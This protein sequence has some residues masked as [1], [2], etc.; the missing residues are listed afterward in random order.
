M[1]IGQLAIST[2]ILIGYLAILSL[3]LIK[4]FFRDKTERLL[5]IY[6]AISAV[7]N[8]PVALAWGLPEFA[9]VAALSDQIA[10]SGL[11]ILAVI[12]MN[13]THTFL[14]QTTRLAQAWWILS[15]FYVLV[16]VTFASGFIPLTLPYI[17]LG[18]QIVGSLTLIRVF[19]VLAWAGFTLST[20]IS[21]WRVYREVTSP[22]HRN[23]YRYWLVGLMLLVLGD[24]LFATIQPALR[25]LGICIRL[26]SALIFTITIIRYRLVD[27]KT[28][29]RNAFGYVTIAFLSI[30]LSLALVW[31]GQQ[32]AGPQQAMYGTLGGVGVTAL[33]LAFTSAPLRTAIQRFVDYRLFHIRVNYEALLRAYGEKVIETLRLEPLADLI[34]D[35]LVLATDIQRGALYLVRE[36][37]QEIG[38]LLLDPVRRIGDMP[39]GSFELHP[40]SPLAA[41]LNSSDEPLTQYDIDLRQEFARILPD[42]HEWLTAINIEMFLPIHTSARLVG[43]IVLGAKG[44]GEVYTPDEIDWLKALADQTAVALENARLFDQVETMSVNV[45]RLNADLERAYQKLQEVDKL[46]SAFIGIIT[47]ELRSPFVAAG[48]SVQLLHRYLERKMYT[49]L[50]MQIQQ[51]EKELSSGRKMIDSVISFSSLLS[52]QGQL[53]LE[54]TDLVALIQQTVEPLSKMAQ[55]RQISLTVQLSSRLPKI[56][57][58]SRQLTEAIYHMVH[59]AIKFNHENGWVRVICW[60]TETHVVFKVEDTGCGIPADKLPTLWDGF[61][62]AAD[63]L[64]RGVEGLGLGLA[65]IK[66][67]VQTHGGEVWVNSQVGQGSTFGFR[68]PINARPAAIEAA[69]AV[70]AAT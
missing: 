62:Q 60:P 41:R 10:L 52:K 7:W 16:S 39:E 17:A 31:G 50:Q 63:G 69:A 22:M 29:Y 8:V 25:L 15:I 34:M 9:T 58:D 56:Q 24:A 21:T 19:N 27:I 30:G 61:T 53:Q 42:E 70:P 65:L 4:R 40:D 38:G 48:F 44:S 37:K 26:S 5:V 64:K 20:I 13:L 33:I 3:L 23:R 57:A 14:R 11:I 28:V 47:H 18:D 35:T 49:E 68:I 46:K 45:M 59:N 43:L 54:E 55:S 12:F 66:F 1:N 2:V 67:V 36:G 6:L 51:L 32:I